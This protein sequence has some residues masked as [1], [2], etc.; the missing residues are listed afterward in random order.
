MSEAEE[1]AV[2]ALRQIKVY[3]DSAVL[4]DTQLT[5]EY[6]MDTDNHIHCWRIYMGIIWHSSIKGLG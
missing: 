4:G 3:A 2:E 1:R 6:V 5:D